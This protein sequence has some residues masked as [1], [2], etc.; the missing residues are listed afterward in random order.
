MGSDEVTARISELNLDGARRSLLRQLQWLNQ[1]KWEL[2]NRDVDTMSEDQVYR[3][4]NDLR[5]RKANIRETHAH[6]ER[7]ENPPKM[8]FDGRPMANRE[9]ANVHREPLAADDL[10]EVKGR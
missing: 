5:E 10:G 1:A 8:I 3:A 9:E 2:Q 6:I 4:V 7:L